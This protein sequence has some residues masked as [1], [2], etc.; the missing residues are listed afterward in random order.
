MTESFSWE[1]TQKPILA[2]APMADMT[3]SPYCQIVKE[4]VK[5]RVHDSR[6]IV[7]REMVSS[8]ALVRESTKTLKM[9]EIDDV[10]RPLIQQI[11]GSSPESMVKAAQIIQKEHNPEGIDI[12]MGCPAHKI[13]SSFN[14][15]ALMRDPEVATEIVRKVKESITVPL[16]VKMRAGW[17]DHE[18]CIEFAKKIEAAGAD[19]ITIHGRTK[20]QGYS[21]IANRDVVRRAKEGVSIPMLYNGD[22]FTWENY[23]EAIEETGT[24][25]ALIGRGA[26]GN[27][28]IF[29][30][31][32]Q[33]LHGIE[34][35]EVS[36]EERV[37]I[38]LMHLRLHLEHYGE[39]YIATFRK[40]LAWYFK[41][42]PNFKDTK[43]LLVRAKTE[44]EI[45]DILTSSI[46]LFNT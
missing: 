34:A 23:F 32:E 36:F 20:K 31:I 7:F 17:I 8:E 12:N 33:K 6:I 4:V 13:T 28:W 35:T 10:E 37:E 30:Q 39:Q 27:P 3:D 38:V 19:I 1:N 44:Q 22:I 14:G 5:R 16:S 9:A 18:E 21:G 46:P 40:H 26:L 11:F 24:N 45:I 15:C 41:G 29:A 42:I 25:G 2:L 43:A